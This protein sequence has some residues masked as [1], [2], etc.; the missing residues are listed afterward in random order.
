MLAALLCVALGA[1][2]VYGL[3]GV[4]RDVAHHFH[5]TPRHAVASAHRHSVKEGAAVALAVSARFSTPPTTTAPSVSPSPESPAA[6]T[7]APAVGGGRPRLAIIID[8]CGNSME[9]DGRFLTLPIPLTMSILPMTPHALEIAQAAEAA[10]KHVILHL[11]MEPE[12]AAVHPGPGAVTT[13]M[14]DDQ[15][16]S[17]VAAD[18]AALPYVPGANNHMGSKATSDARVMRDVMQVLKKDNRFFIDSMTSGASVGASTAREMGVPTASRDVFLDNSAT[19]SYVEGQ[20]NEAM[21]VALKDGEAIAIG[22]PNPATAQALA[23]LIPQI[24]AAGVTFVSADTL[25]R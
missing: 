19:V 15:V 20:L 3:L 17:Q 7:I 18:L 21:H 25:V 22:H 4:K 13:A 14:T 12:S 11:P 10:G 16:Q 5:Q 8:D 6:A 2:V 24:Q 9:R 1:A 23:A